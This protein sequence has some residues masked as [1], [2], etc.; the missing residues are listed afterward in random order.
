MKNSKL[1]FLLKRY[2]SSSSMTE[3]GQLINLSDKLAFCLL[4]GVNGQCPP[5]TNNGCHNN[6]C[7]QTLNP[8]NSACYNDVCL[9]FGM[10]NSSCTN[11]ACEVG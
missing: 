10:T 4:G 7:S 6:G 8:N 11:S 1:E 3:D 9:P 2:Q 5:E